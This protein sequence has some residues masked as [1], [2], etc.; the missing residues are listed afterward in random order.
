MIDGLR[1]ISQAFKEG[2]EIPQQYTC[3][4]ENIS[5]ALSIISAPEG[6]KSYTLIMHDPDAAAGD[7]VHWSL[8]DIPASTDSIGTNSVPIGAVQGLN[9]TGSNKYVGPCPPDGTG[10]HHYLFE[11]Y[12]LDAPLSLPPETTRDKLKEAMK[13]HILDLVTLTGTFSAKKII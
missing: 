4:G 12:A 2:E 13:G 7:F 3:R 1:L 11:L 9:S 6:T 8:W 10:I 5:P